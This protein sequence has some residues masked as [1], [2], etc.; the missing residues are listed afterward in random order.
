VVRD[1]ALTP[2]RPRL[3]ALPFDLPWG[4]RGEPPTGGLGA[5]ATLLQLREDHGTNA[6]NKLAEGRTV[7]ASQAAG[8]DLGSAGKAAHH[9]RDSKV[10]PCGR[11]FGPSPWLTH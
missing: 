10:Q 2:L 7:A 11:R 6:M 1:I 4:T 9:F 3:R 5:L 8:R